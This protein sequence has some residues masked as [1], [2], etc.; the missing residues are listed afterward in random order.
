LDLE[1]RLAGL[2]QSPLPVWV[3]DPEGPRWVW[4]NARA[5]AFWKASDLEEF[6]ARDVTNLTPAAR[7]RL[8]GTVEKLRDGRVLEEQW[9]FYPRGEP[10]TVMLAISAI[11][12]DD[13]RMGML[14]HALIAHD[15]QDDEVVRGIEALRHTPVIVALLDI[16]GRLIFQNPAAARAFGPSGPFEA[17]FVDPADARRILGATRAN[18]HFEAELWT[19]TTQGERWHA[20]AARMTVDPVTGHPAILLHQTDETRRRGAERTA[21]SKTRLAEELARALAL[22][23]ERNK[24]ILLLSAPIIEV[25]EGMLAVPIVGPLDGQRSAGIAARLLP[26]IMASRATTVLL[27][28][29]GTEAADAPVPQSIQ[30]LIRAIQLLGARPVITGMRA[31]LARLLA[32][33]GVDMTGVLTLATLRQGID[34]CRMLGNVQ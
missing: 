23:E 14:Q 5:L 33:E 24:Q 27:D 22:V 15:R 13:G 26:A 18:D 32:R 1:Q 11:A 19:R 12:L 3:T 2:S 10:V 7:A 28:M 25:G 21:A 20:V 8:A 31:H 29:T 34:T 4:A 6:R 17:W 9:T 16:D 30:S